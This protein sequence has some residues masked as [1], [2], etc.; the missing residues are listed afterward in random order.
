[1]RPHRGGQGPLSRSAV[2]SQQLRPAVR[3]HPPRDRRA[4]GQPAANLLDGGHRQY[5]P[6]P[7]AQLAAGLGA[8]LTRFSFGAAQYRSQPRDPK[9]RADRSD[10]Q[11]RETWETDMVIK[12]GLAA[13]A[14]LLLSISSAQA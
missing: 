12:N 3:G 2:T 11:C 13:A 14:L 1:A 6:H 7:L 5:G 4:V 10:L 8:A 9:G